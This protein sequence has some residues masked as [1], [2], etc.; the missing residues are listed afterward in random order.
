ME[1]QQPAVPERRRWARV[2]CL[3]P[4]EY[5]INEMNDPINVHTIDIG[6]GGMRIKNPFPIDERY[7]FP[8]RIFLGEHPV[9]ILARAAWQAKLEDEEMYEIGLEFVQILEEDQE[10][11]ISFVD[12]RNPN[13]EGNPHSKKSKAATLRNR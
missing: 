6:G 2:N 5:Y 7:Q 1:N 4:V 11:I 10:K 8:M 9:R 3:L 13:K 12:E